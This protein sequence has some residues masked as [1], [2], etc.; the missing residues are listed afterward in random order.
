MTINYHLPVGYQENLERRTFDAES[1][2]TYWTSARINAANIYQ[3]PVYD[4]AS[5]LVKAL[6][7]SRLLDIGCG[8]APK[9]AKLH[10]THPNLEISGID[11]PSAIQYCKETY[12][13]GNWLVDDFENTTL[14]KPEDKKPQLMICADVIEHI[15]KPELLLNYFKAWAT[16]ETVILLSTPERTRTRGKDALSCPHPDHVREWAADEL[17]A[18]LRDHGFEILEQCYMLPVKLALNKVSF[19]ALAK[20]IKRRLPLKTNQVILMKVAS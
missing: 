14:E 8:P 1:G 7:V 19:H 10:K 3:W 6:G 12:D 16:P 18:F 11:Q 17:A 4:Y 2:L 5:H 20:Q 13:F 9:L 15:L